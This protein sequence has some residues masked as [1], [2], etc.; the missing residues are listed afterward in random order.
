MT[1]EEF[2]LKMKALGNDDEYIEEI[3]YSHHNDEFIIPY[4]AYLEEMPS[5][6]PI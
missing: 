3:I 5:P 6:G 2:R 4:E 1:D